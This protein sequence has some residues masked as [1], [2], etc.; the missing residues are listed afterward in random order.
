MTQEIVKNIR[1]D[2][3]YQ[4]FL[5]GC[6]SIIVESKFNSQVEILKGK[7]L[8]GKNI[9]EEELNLSKPEYGERVMEML[10]EDLDISV[11]H[12][13]KVAQ[14]YKRYKLDQF[15]KVIEQLPEGKAI[16]WYKMCQD[17]LP[18][19][20]EEQVKTERIEEL[21]KECTHPIL[22]CKACG[23]ELTMAELLKE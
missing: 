22:K 18:K 17:V 10:A 1:E 3:K 20:R 2:E 15:D 9:V 21:Q 5:E 6:R 11:S 23:K 8:L 12:I 7:W 19:P 4:Y 13:F 14:F 16:S